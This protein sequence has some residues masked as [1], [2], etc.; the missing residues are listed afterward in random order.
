[1]VFPTPGDSIVNTELRRPGQL[2]DVHD[3]LVLTVPGAAPAPEPLEPGPR[4]VEVDGFR[5]DLTGDALAA[6]RTD[7]QF[8][9]TDAAT[10]GGPRSPSPAAR[11]VPTSACTPN[12]PARAGTASGVSSG[13]PTAASI[14]VPFT[15]EAS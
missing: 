14:A 3:R 5:V 1:M 4:S 13:W 12:C 15:V 2:T 10:R 6:G 11:S 8:R 9:F 7:L